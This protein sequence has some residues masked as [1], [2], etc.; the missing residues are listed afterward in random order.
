MRNLVVMLL[1]LVTAPVQASTYKDFVKVWDPR[2]Q[3]YRSERGT[4]ETNA[5]SSASRAL[6]SVV[7]DDPAGPDDLVMALT[8]AW[9]LSELVGRGQT[10][11]VFREHMG[12]KPSAALSE[13]WMQGKV[14]ELRRR[15]SEADMVERQMNVLRDRAR[16][17]VGEW[18][19]ALERLSMMRGTIAG[20]AAELVLINQNLG[21]YY[22]ARSEEQAASAALWGSVLLALSTAARDSQD[23]VQRWSADCARGGNCSRR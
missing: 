11:Y 15:Q 13:A 20:T 23:G 1:L 21:S 12:S 2:D 14:D 6:E 7:S 22:R 8:A 16:G 5:Q 3:S 19:A 9:S 10:L 4:L 17:T 18:I